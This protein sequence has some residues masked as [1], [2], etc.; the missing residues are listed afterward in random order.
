MQCSR[1]TVVGAPSAPLD[2]PV[3]SCAQESSDGDAE[4]PATAAPGAAAAVGESAEWRQRVQGSAA[5]LR[6]LGRH[7]RP[8]RRACSACRG[9]SAHC[10]SRDR[11]WQAAST[12]A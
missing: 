3:C 10:S 7:G 9:H 11:T 12:A 5:A 6:Q 8:N 1:C 4:G 2:V